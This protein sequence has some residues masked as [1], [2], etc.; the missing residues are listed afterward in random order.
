MA[1]G[2]EARIA[3]RADGKSRMNW[4]SERV[5]RGAAGNV[6]PSAEQLRQWFAARDQFVRGNVE[7]GLALARTCNHEDARW[8]TQT[9]FPGPPPAD[10]RDV[11]K[12][13]QLHGERARDARALC[14]YGMLA[15]KFAFVARAAAMGDGLAMAQMAACSPWYEKRAWGERAAAAGEPEGFAWLGLCALQGVVGCEGDE[16]RAV[17]LLRQAANLDSALGA[18]HFARVGFRACEPEKFAWLARA[19]AGGQV[20]ADGELCAAFRTH[21][22]ALE[23]GRPNGPVLFELGSALRG[24]VA[25]STL[26]GC[27]ATAYDVEAA[28]WAIQLHLETCL[29]AKEAVFEWI[30]VGK[31]LRVVRDMRRAIAMLL[32]ANR[33]S[34]CRP[35]ATDLERPGKKMQR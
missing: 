5:V 17:A 19:A 9:V 22:C 20:L 26:F 8:L 34:W 3:A 35:V 25:N 12:V 31:R 13:L 28:K 7:G 32:W 1:T 14:L 15:K 4:W 27:C 11:L 29:A 10:A 21:I 33:R 18:Y 6:E 16:A 30:S 2:L 24:R 23:E